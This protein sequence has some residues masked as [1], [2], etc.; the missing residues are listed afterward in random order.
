MKIIK[1]IF[2]IP[3]SIIKL[4]KKGFYTLSLFLSR[5]FYFYLEKL[6]T[7]LGKIFPFKFIH[8][9]VDYFNRMKEQPNHIVS[10]I[11]WFLCLLY[12]FDTFYI[13]NTVYTEE[14]FVEG[15]KPRKQIQ[16]EAPK[17]IIL[18][19]EFNLYRI[20]G[21]YSIE[22]INFDQLKEKNAQTVAWI[23]VE[24]TNINY[25]VVQTTDNDYYLT[26]S[27]DSAP[28]TG[29]WPFIDYRNDNFN[30]KNTIFYGHNLLNETS[31]GGI[32]K[33]ISN[34]KDTRIIV[35]TSDGK[36]RIYKVFSGYTIEPETY[37]LQTD[38][39]DDND[40]QTFLDTL[41]QRNKMSINVPVTTSNQIIT[42]ST[43][44]NDNKGRSVIHAKLVTTE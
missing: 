38:F 40:Y 14:A 11:I 39:N 20:Y 22:D 41:V 23:I 25:P 2:F 34:G 6:F 10:L 12:L 42:L 44:T 21:K 3:I 16:E 32:K 18:N 43:C 8:N 9:L 17:S 5:G 24:N 7:L 37:Y 31:F 36:K 26:H 35:L 30:D 15:V 28:S 29:G 19:K 4:F 1:T 13:N 27:F 33:V